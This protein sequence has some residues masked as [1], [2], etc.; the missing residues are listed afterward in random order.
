MKT[1]ISFEIVRERSV[2]RSMIRYWNLDT[3]K[4]EEFMFDVDD[5]RQTQI[6]FDGYYI[7]C[8]GH[9]TSAQCNKLTPDYSTPIVLLSIDFNPRIGTK[10]NEFQRNKYNLAGGY[11][12]VS[13]NRDK[14]N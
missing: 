11:Y 9:S 3:N 6:S 1:D 5:S 10:N 2:H 14:G 4:M 12:N 8:T 7:R 13:C